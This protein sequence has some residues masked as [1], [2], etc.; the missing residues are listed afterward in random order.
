VVLVIA[1]VLGLCGLAVALPGVARQL[2]PRRFTAAQ[3]RQI[4]AWEMARRWRSLP[5]GTIFPATVSYRLPGFALNVNGNRGLSLRA[6]RLG[7]A[8]VVRC[9]RGAG[10]AAARILDS[11]GCTAMLRAT[12]VDSTGSLV[13]TVGV[14]VL[15][16]ATDATTA[17]TRL[18]QAGPPGLPGTVRAAAVPDTLASRY[19]D[20]QRQLSWNT[21]AGP[22]VILTTTGFSDGRPRVRVMADSYMSNEM[23]SLNQGLA[24]SVGTVLGRAP[25]KPTCPGAPGC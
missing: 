8:A 24:D 21:H 20:A 17:T 23:G 9:P 2:L 15:P 14:A 10:P 1:L 18:A 12:Y 3:Q 19:D 7:V 16:D 25:A 6:H 22:Y 13:T 5:E 11:Y 4:E